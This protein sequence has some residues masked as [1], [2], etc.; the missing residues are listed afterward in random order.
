MMMVQGRMGSPGDPAP[1]VP[2]DIKRVLV[3]KGMKPGDIRG[4]HTHRKMQQVIFAI[5][6]GC[7]VELDNGKEKENVRL[8]SFNKG[9]LLSPFIWHVMRDFEPHTILL[10]FGDGEY[11]EKEYIRNYDHFLELANK[12]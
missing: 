11:D 10:V 8:D 7:F 9:L 5:S 3:M 6:G 4:G 1:C 2:F 12:V